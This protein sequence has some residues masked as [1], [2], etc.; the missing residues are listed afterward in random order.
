MKKFL[1][2]LIGALAVVTMFGGTAEAHENDVE[3]T[4]VQANTPTNVDGKI[5]EYIPA[6]GK[7]EAILTNEMIVAMNKQNSM[8]ARYGTTIVSNHYHSYYGPYRDKY[9]G[10][11]TSGG[12]AYHFWSCGE[13][14]RCGF[15]A[16]RFHSWPQR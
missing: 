10:I 15:S 4:V 14:S 2:S 9:D 16:M 11:W 3:G 6:D 8:L 7:T 13:R 12:A 1:L 5:Y